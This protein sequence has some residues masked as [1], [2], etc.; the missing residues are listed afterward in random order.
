MKS[1]PLSVQLLVDGTTSTDVSE[2]FQRTYEGIPFQ[3]CWSCS[4]QLEEIGPLHFVEKHF[5]H[6]VLDQETA[7]CNE[8]KQDQQE[9]LSAESLDLVNHF[10]KRIMDERPNNKA[11][12]SGIAKQCALCATP[13]NQ[14]QN[15]SMIAGIKDDRIVGPIFP[16]LLCKA[17][18][19]DLKLSKDSE[20][21]LRE[22]VKTTS[23][24]VST[25][26]TEVALNQLRIGLL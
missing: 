15:Y 14:L 12:P 19:E 1:L 21:G 20:N 4:R 2:F 16:L 13:E 9:T 24:Q 17:C 18:Q 7:T 10:L 25:E 8:C 3:D 5:I 6:G 22:V 26:Q 11:A 23:I